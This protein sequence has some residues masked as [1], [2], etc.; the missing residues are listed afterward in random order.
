METEINEE[1]TA[2]EMKA[3]SINY[4]T[5]IEK[6]IFPK[7]NLAGRVWLSAAVKSQVENNNIMN[8]EISLSF[9]LC[10]SELS[11]LSYYEEVHPQF[12]VN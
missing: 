9:V 4:L 8:Q 1:L 10:L 7:L 11:E 12:L 2:G 5:E 6:E 3:L